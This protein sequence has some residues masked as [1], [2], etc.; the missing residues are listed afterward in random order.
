MGSLSNLIGRLGCLDPSDNLLKWILLDRPF[1]KALQ[2][3]CFIIRFEKFDPLVLMS[4]AESGDDGAV[5]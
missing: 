1:F 3:S 2:D 5:T 4:R